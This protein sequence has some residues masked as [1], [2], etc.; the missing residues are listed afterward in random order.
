[1]ERFTIQIPDAILDD[2]RE[3][4]RRTRFP[5]P[6]PGT[7]WSQGVDADWLREAVRHW[8]ERYDWR[9]AE[10]EMNR[11]THLRTEISGNP[12]HFIHAPSPKAD[13]VPLI[14]T[15][16]WPGSFL[17]MMRVLPL[18]VDAGFHVVVPSLPGFGFSAPLHR[19]GVSLWSIA[20]LWAE[21]MTRLGYGR[22]IAQGGDLGAG[23]STCLGLR[24]PERL[25]GLHLN[26]IPGSYRP[27]PAGPEPTAEER[28]FLA[29]ADAW[30]SADGGYWHEQA[31]RPATI[32]AALDD[33][34]AGL[35]AW[36][37]EKLREWSDCGG[38]LE[39]RFSLDEVLTHVTLYW[40][41]QT[42]TSSSR[43]Y[44]ETR[45]HPVRFATGDRVRVPTAVARFPLE[46]PFPP[47]SWIER[48][49]D[50]HRFTEMP[51][52]GHFAAW[53]EPEL[54]AGDLRA[55]LGQLTT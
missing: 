46:A 11:W 29:S 41:T 53:E 51:R 22:F 38:D 55:F 25:I 9:T 31:T 45:L 4:L 8:A 14:V 49:Y 26:Y 7:G 13:A 2:L 19:T 5:P 30:Y 43:L 23:V 12:I 16:G 44:Y 20:D 10:R 42:A 32:G 39:R 35:L 33:S 40:I 28:A 24:H 48:G 1:M 18:L 34:P 50:V 15:H 54:L 6:I 21:L 37:G 36:I 47:R 3:R 27:D 17:E 52:G